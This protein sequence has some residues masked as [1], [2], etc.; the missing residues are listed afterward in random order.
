MTSIEPQSAT[1]KPK[2]RW[3]QPTPGACLAALLVVEGSL[4]LAEWFRWL[5]KY[6]I[7]LIAVAA[8]VVVPLLTLFCFGLALIF[9]W[10]FQFSIRTMLAAATLF[11][12]L[13]AFFSWEVKVA[14]YQ[15]RCAQAIHSRGG[16]VYYDYQAGTNG[17]NWTA[18]SQVPHCLL[19]WLGK[20][21]FHDVVS[22]KIRVLLPPDWERDHEESA[23]DEGC[24]SPG[25]AVPN[26]WEREGTQGIGIRKIIWPTTVR[27]TA[28]DWAR[29][30]LRQQQFGCDRVAIHVEYCRN[31]L[32]MDP[33]NIEAN[34]LLGEDP[35][36]GEDEDEI[37]VHLTAVLASAKPDSL[38][39]AQARK[40]LA[41]EPWTFAELCQRIGPDGVLQ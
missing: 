26:D 14:E 13:C 12:L 39:Y 33:H 35:R 1:P 21:F 2:L 11:A 9:R 37:R 18:D 22:V 31:A 5:P 16:T 7:G 17:F 29:A 15:R 41:S 30:A 3:F 32:K 23:F 36:Y 25:T 34:L 8:V 6:W 24:L 28:N 38:E 27:L 40:L 20:D 4:F 10:R 19:K